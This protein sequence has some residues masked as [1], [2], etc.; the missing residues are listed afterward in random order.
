MQKGFSLG[1]VGRS[2]LSHEELGAGIDSAENGTLGVPRRVDRNVTSE[3]EYLVG[4]KS[5]L[6]DRGWEV[7]GEGKKGES[8]AQ[9]L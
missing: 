7:G 4:E 3:E 9:D 2:V 5:E 8:L 6:V 1:K